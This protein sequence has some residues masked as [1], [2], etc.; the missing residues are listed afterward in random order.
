[1]SSCSPLSW[2][3]NRVPVITVVM[4]QFVTEMGTRWNLMTRHRRDGAG[5]GFPAGAVRPEILIRGW[6]I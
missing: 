4:A 1:M 5:A 6:R 3:G 2:T